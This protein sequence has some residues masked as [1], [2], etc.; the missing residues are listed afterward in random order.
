F[1]DCHYIAME[2]ISGGDLGERIK[3]YIDFDELVEMMDQV[4]DALDH[5]HAK[6][7]L[8]RDIKPAN[9]LFRDNGDAVVADFGIAKAMGSDTQMTDVGEV[10]GTPVYMSPEQSRGKDIDGRSDLYSVAV[11]V[12]Q[13]LTG[14]PPYNGD[15]SLSI[16]IKH[17]SEPIPSMPEPL[18]EVQPFLDKGMAKDRGQRFASGAELIA[19]L[20]RCLAR[21]KPD[22]LDATKTMILSNLA[23]AASTAVISSRNSE[24]SGA[25]SHH[26]GGRTITIEIPQITPKIG[27]TAG[28]LVLL[29]VA[30]WWLMPGRLSLADKARIDM[31][32]NAARADINA[33]HYYQPEGDNALQ[34]Y[35][36][37]LAIA[38]DHP[39][40]NEALQYLGGLLLQKSEDA[41]K[42][43]DWDSATAMAEQA[44]LLIPDSSAAEQ[45]LADIADAQRQLLEQQQQQ[46]AEAREAAAAQ[47]WPEAIEQ[48]RA[49][50][51]DILESALVQS[52]LSKLTLALVEKG[53]Q[54][55]ATQQFEEATKL[56]THAQ[57]F[58]ALV[59]EPAV[60]D[61]IEKALAA[62]RQQQTTRDKQKRAA[63]TK[64]DNQHRLAGLLQQAE[65]SNSAAQAAGLYQQALNIAPA[66]QQAKAGIRKNSGALISAAASAIST[67]DLDRAKRNLNVVNKLRAD[68]SL[69]SEQVQQ[70]NKLRIDFKVA[71][72]Q[73]AT[74]DKLFSRF[75]RYMEVP[76][77][78]SANKIYRRIITMTTTDRRLTD[79]RQRLANGYLVL[80]NKEAAGR[81]WK[82]A[83]TMCERGLEVLPDHAGLKAMQQK[84]NDN[85]PEG[86]KKI[87]GIF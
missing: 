31:L 40:T 77:V 78:R 22:D 41:E 39:A 7:F 36:Q 25:R 54:E 14:K 59:N 50:P 2:Y 86:R 28:L 62:N 52:E 46:L 66:N 44:L 8:H 74:L 61:P 67:G 20:K 30:A 23:A 37:A 45:Q 65:A 29:V 85:L 1:E 69:S 49:I 34:K 56:L 13:I 10:L 35:R 17:I 15:T 38:P 42:N 72:S 43:S 6:G 68:N 19:E 47:R 4:A 24:H 84:A 27:M 32:L 26:T 21:I 33:G 18:K 71:S 58:A 75:D 70:L 55:T 83:M 48:Y 82:D 79:V 76:K 5:A 16:A 73:R 87:L 3:N 63:Q 81:Y 64:R 57:A 12:F 53:E 11:I 80:A 51:V 9:I 60:S